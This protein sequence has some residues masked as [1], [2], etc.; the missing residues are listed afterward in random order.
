MKLRRSVVV[1]ALVMVAAACNSTPLDNVWPGCTVCVPQ[2]TVANNRVPTRVEIDERVSPA[3]DC[4]PVRTQHTLVVT[5]YD[6]CDQ[7]MPGQRVEWILN[8]FPQAVGDIVAGDDQYGSV[9]FAP[10]RQA[11]NGNNGNK[12]DNHYAASVTN[13]GTE[14]ID[15]GNNYP[16]MSESGA[17]L[18]DI[19]VGPGQSWLTITSTREGVTDITVYVPGIRDGTKHKI[20]A[21]KIWADYDVKFPESAVNILPDDTHS[22]P[23][24]V[25]RT[26]GTGIPGQPVEAEILD[27]P[28][29]VFEGGGTFQTLETNAAGI[30]DF[31]LRNTGGQSGINRIRLTAKGAFYGEYC[32]R[33]QIVTKQWKTVSLNVNC[34]YPGGTTVPVGKPFSKTITITNT[35]DAA[36]EGVMLNDTPSSGLSITSGASFPM[37]IGTIGPGQTVTRSIEMVA[38]ST[39]Q[40]TNRV[41][42]S[43]GGAQAESSCPVEAVQGKLEIT[44]VCEPT[45]ANAGSEVRFVVT[46]TNTGRGPL[47]NVTVVDEYPAGITQTSQNTASIPLLP[48]GQSREVIFTGKA[49]EAGT[50]TNVV[51]GTAEGVQPVSASCTLE[52]VECRLDMELIGPEKIYYGEDAN[53][54]LRVVN[55]GDGDADGCTV[56]VQYGGCLGGGFQDF[57]I[58]PLAPGEDWTHDWSMP[59]KQV[60]PCTVV[61]QSS[62]GARCAIKKPLDVRVTGLPAIQVEMTDKAVDGSEKGIFSIGETFIYRLKVENDAGTEPTPEMKVAFELPPEL[63]FVQGG[64]INGQATVSGEGQQA[65][66]SGFVLDVNQAI[67]FEFTV[68]VRS[69]P[70]S[71]LVRVEARILRAADDAELANETESTTLKR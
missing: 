37:S 57:N 22:F 23:V 20:W 42:V 59:A 47:E 66:T 12:F 39:G 54:T 31:R 27:G 9:G 1:L 62:C 50:Y 61:A 33:T 44:K 11:F 35:G 32:P 55:N 48:A 3:V 36:A 13:F 6:Q 5:V 64:A 29:A 16:Y 28:A 40:H 41:S 63:E 14:S 2:P 56:R 52:V 15:A 10:M 65:Q 38:N 43:G 69:A 67:D 17:R 19:T 34:S 4:N 24:T 25:M 60:G 46:V 53:F 18:P 58:G 49:D 8:R 51:R 68:R 45:K 70:A 7:P 71:G 26:D 21:K 30:A